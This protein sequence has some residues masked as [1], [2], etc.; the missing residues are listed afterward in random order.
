MVAGPVDLLGARRISCSRS[1]ILAWTR[2]LSCTGASCSHRCGCSTPIGPATTS[3]YLAQYLL[4]QR[5]VPELQVHFRDRRGSWIIRPIWVLSWKHLRNAR[6]LRPAARAQIGGILN[7]AQRAAEGTVL[8]P[9][10]IRTIPLSAL[11][12][13]VCIEFVSARFIP[14]T[15]AP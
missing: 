3:K 11:F 14:Y 13:N 4:I 1:L 5:T 15:S 9:A 8:R 7:S 2:S 6:A 12:N 10:L